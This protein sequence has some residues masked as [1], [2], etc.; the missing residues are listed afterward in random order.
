MGGSGDRRAAAA[1]APAPVVAVV[2]ALLAAGANPGER[3]L[4]TGVLDLVASL[5]VTVL[6][7]A[8]MQGVLDPD[9]VL[10]RLGA[11][12]HAVR[13][14]LLVQLG[15]SSGGGDRVRHQPALCRQAADH[16]DHG[17]QRCREQPVPHDGSSLRWRR[18]LHVTHPRLLPEALAGR[19]HPRI[20]PAP[21]WTSPRARA[22]SR[23]PRSSS[24]CAAGPPARAGRTAGTLRVRCSTSPCRTRSGPRPS[25]RATARARRTRHR[26][27]GAA[28]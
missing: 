2:L 28:P 14:V 4:V 5:V 11:Q 23:R 3:I 24:P 9:R 26:E 27:S 25:G 18:F 21:T 19:A 7:I 16:D 1:P 13:A 22:T 10:E 6:L 12:R 15:G 17:E 20:R 8:V